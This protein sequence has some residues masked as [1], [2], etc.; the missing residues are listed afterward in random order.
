MVP[1]TKQS[2]SGCGILL[3]H[4]QTTCAVSIKFCTV[5]RHVPWIKSCKRT[6]RRS[7]VGICVEVVFRTSNASAFEFWTIVKMSKRVNLRVWESENLVVLKVETI[8][9]TTMK[10]IVVATCIRPKLE[11]FLA[12]FAIVKPCFLARRGLG[13][14]WMTCRQFPLWRGQPK[15]PRTGW[16]K[17]CFSSYTTPLQHTTYFLT[18]NFLRLC[19]DVLT[20]FKFASFGTLQDCTNSKRNCEAAMVAV[21]VGYFGK[22]AWQG[23]IF[24][25]VNISCL[26][27]R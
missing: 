25:K 23:F 9:Q 17:Y 12:D 24:P 20:W 2:R 26:K 8:P 6:K 10:H 21:E 1:C 5:K 18:S 7:T 22:I 15:W 14:T 27:E 19:N 3:W 11:L 13:V 16:T 4:C